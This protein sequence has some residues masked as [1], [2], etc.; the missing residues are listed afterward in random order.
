MTAI[1]M[2]PEAVSSDIARIHD[3]VPTWLYG[4]TPIQVLHK[5]AISGGSLGNV[6]RKDMRSAR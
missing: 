5:N 1:H 4:R 2:L 3:A 6:C